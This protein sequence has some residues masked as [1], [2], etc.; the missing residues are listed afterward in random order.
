MKSLLVSIFLVGIFIGLTSC[1]SNDVEDTPPQEE[2]VVT[3]RAKPSPEP[4]PNPPYWATVTGIYFSIANPPTTIPPVP[5]MVDAVI[6]LSDEYILTSNGHWFLDGLTWNGITPVYGDTMIVNGMVSEHFDI[7]N[8]IYVE[9]E[10][11]QIQIVTNLPSQ[12]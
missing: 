7:G 1:E 6:D 9:I 12:P 5:A 11:D 2:K 4:I 8:N 3:K 10:V